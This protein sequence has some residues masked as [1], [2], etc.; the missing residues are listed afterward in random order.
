MENKQ[1]VYIIGGCRTA[2][3]T[4][5]GAFKDT[6]AHEL[7]TVVIKEVLRRANVKPQDVG[8]VIM[9][10]VL[11]AGQ[12]QNPARMAAL[13]A[14]IPI[15]IPAYG[16]NML[17]GSG[18]KAVYS[19]W[20]SIMSGQA[21]VV[22]AGGQENMSMARHTALLRSGTKLG[23]QT[24]EDS[25]LTDGL[26]D[27]KLKIHMGNTAEHLSKKFNISREKQDEFALKSQTKA[28]AAI[29]NNHFR[30]E[31]VP[32]GVG[33]KEITQVTEDEHVRK[34]TTLEKLSRLRP[35]FTKDGTVTAGNASGI[36][37]GAAA[38]IL[39]D[40][41]YCNSHNIQK[42]FKIIAFAQSGVEPIEMG[43]GP[44][45]AV[46]A[47]LKKANW[48]VDDVDLYE[49]NEAFAVQ[50]HICVNQ[51]GIPEEKVNIT[52]GAIALGHPIGASGARVLVTLIY[53]MKRLNKNK[54]VAALCIGGGMGI[55]IAVERVES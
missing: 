7:G 4:F 17:C 19:G 22:V 45:V 43:L 55:A 35:S 3:G 1:S 24:F 54:G 13:D 25:L 29:L 9:G 5:C 14:G 34:G 41:S 47:V 15:D 8:E 40:E 27:S 50:S 16:V 30:D 2:I 21:S 33:K 20:Q 18:L 39:A 37:D 44:I 12:G 38:V 26:V 42:Q 31:I 51:I 46:P 11:T 49:L 28:E 52:G 6:P 32:V 36:N 48:S 53:N 10:Q 23:P